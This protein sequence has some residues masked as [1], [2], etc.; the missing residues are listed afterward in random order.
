MHSSFLD[1]NLKKS[2]P[3]IPMAALLL[4]ACSQLRAELYTEGYIGALFGRASIEKMSINNIYNH[5]GLTATLCHMPSKSLS[6]SVIGGFRFGGW[7]K[8][9]VSKY[10]GIYGDLALSKLNYHHCFSQQKIFY[11][12][13]TG[14]GTG[15][16][17]IDF[18]SR[19]HAASL[20]FMV[21]CR[22]FLFKNDRYP[23]GQLQPYLGIGPAFFVAKECARIVIGPHEVDGA[24][25]AI[26]LNSSYTIAPNKKSSKVAA[27]GA[28]DVGLQQKLPHSLSLDYG[29][30]Y[31]FS[32][33]KVCFCP[34]NSSTGQ[35]KLECKSRYNMLSLHI[36]LSYSF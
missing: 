36:G 5:P 17:D 24:H 18:L 29:L 3:I 22:A 28:L 14:P 27:C 30:N 1:A 7:L 34:V 10:F 11:T 21:A 2:I 31:R 33:C 4:M 19:G 12:S 35:D 26:L 16:A 25:L 32:P 9:R 8:G 13:N 23:D 15:N 6:P 20:A